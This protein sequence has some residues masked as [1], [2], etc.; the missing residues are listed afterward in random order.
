MLCPRVYGVFTF[1]GNVLG[2]FSLFMLPILSS[3]F[4][5]FL[6]TS[7]LFPLAAHAYPV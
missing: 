7:C 6:C 2:L 3:Y 1:A 5:V 4:F